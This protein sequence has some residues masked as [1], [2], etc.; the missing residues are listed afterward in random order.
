MHIPVLL[1]QSIKNLNI[2]KNGIYIDA[3]FGSGGHSKEILKKIGKKGILYSIDRDPESI[4]IA[5]N[6]KD[7]RFH[8]IH[9]LFSNIHEYC[10]KY[11]IL[12][13]INGVILDL[14]ISSIQLNNSNRGFSFKNNGPLDMRMNQKIGIP[15]SK[16]L[17]KTTQKKIF[18]ILKKYGEERYSKKISVSIIKNRKIKPILYTHQLKK[19]ISKSI[20]YQK[21]HS[22]RRSFQAIRIYLN[23]ELNELKKF[24][25]NVLK[26]LS[27]NG[28]LC[29]ISFHSL[30][31]RIVKK[32][33]FKNSR[34]IPN[35]PS[36]IPLTEKEL[37]KINKKKCKLKIYKK[38]FPN[39][40]EILKNI[41]SR[42]AI[43]RIA[44][45]KKK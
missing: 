34:K 4:K 33:M 30:E 11:N 27:P 40:K 20:P 16:W 38:I 24:L 42:S 45:L 29:I 22:S 10:K 17:M 14:G 5:K 12:K 43:L 32:F 19:I 21:K 6:I 35:L 25:K 2:K 18:T 3:T 26:I 31:D 36:S 37:L 1:K 28:K 39:K 15:A 44:K 8:I 23:N 41:R 9:G 7:S 13:K